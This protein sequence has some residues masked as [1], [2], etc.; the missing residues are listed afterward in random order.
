MTVRTWFGLAF[1]VMALA[2]A[3]AQAPPTN[4]VFNPSP[5]S[6]TVS[7]FSVTITFCLA[8]GYRSHKV[9]LNG[10]NITSSFSTPANAGTCTGAF[11]GDIKMTETGTV[12]PA[13]GINVLA[14]SVCESNNSR[15]G[16]P[17]CFNGGMTFTHNYVSV[18]PKNL[19]GPGPVSQTVTEQFAV[20][21][22]L[23]TA[24]TFNLAVVCSGSGVS[25]C[26]ISPASPLHIAGSTT[27]PVTVSFTSGLRNSTGL[28]KLI[29]T[30]SAQ[31]AASD[32]GSINYTAQ[33]IPSERVSTAFTS[34]AD[35]DANR[36]AEDCFAT[37]VK[38]DT[39][40]Y[41]SLD[42]ARGISLVYNS[43]EVA[44]RPVLYADVQIIPGQPYSLQGFQLSAKYYDPGSASWLTI[45]FLNGDQILHFAAVSD[46]LVHRLAGQFDA[47]AL[48]TNSGQAVVRLWMQIITSYADHSDTVSDSTHRLML[49]NGRQ[50]SVAQGWSIAG[51]SDDNWG[52]GPNPDQS[53]IMHYEGSGSTFLTG[54]VACFSW[55]CNW[56]PWDVA[57]AARL[58]YDNLPYAELDFPDSTK[59]LFQP[60]GQLWQRISRF[61]DTVTYTYDA[62]GRVTQISDPYRFQPS[63]NNTLHTYWTITYGSTWISSIIEPDSAG[64]PG[65]GRTTS[66]S[67]DAQG[68]LRSWTD[69]DHVVTKFGYDSQNR[70]DSLTD[71][72]GG[73]TTYAY[74]PNSWKLVGVTSPSVLIDNT[75]SG[76]PTPQALV[77]K[78][79]P[80]QTI[81]VP[82]TS[83]SGTPATPV[84]LSAVVAVDS[85]SSG[86][87][88]FSVNSYGQPLVVL[89]PMGDTSTF[90]YTGQGYLEG[91]IHPGGAMDAY[92]WTIPFL[93]SLTPSGAST[94]TVK[95][96]AYG[97][98]IQVSSDGLT[99]TAYIG[100]Y[101]H[102]DSVKVNGG[103]FHF[104][105]D[106]YVRDTLVVDAAHD[107]T[108]FRYDLRTGNMDSVIL[109]PSYRF[110]AKTFDGHGRDRTISSS[111]TNGVVVQT[112]AYDSVDRIVSTTDGLHTRPTTFAYDS[113]FL[114]SIT[115]PKG[116]QY[117]S[118]YNA[119]G[120]LLTET[121]SANRTASSTYSAMSAPTLE[122]NRRLQP[123]RFAY[124]PFGRLQ[125]VTRPASETNNVDVFRYSSPYG[126]VVVDSNVLVKDST[127]NSLKTGLADSSVTIFLQTGHW[128]KRK[129]TRDSLGRVTNM[130]ISTNAT[131]IDFYT[132]KSTFNPAT[133]LPQFLDLNDVSHQIAFG[134]DSILR[135]A[136]IAYP[137]GVQ[138]NDAYYSGTDAIASSSWSGLTLSRGY[139]YDSTGK[140][141][142]VDYGAGNYG[143]QSSLYTYDALGELTTNQL[144]VWKDS[145]TSCPGG[146]LQNGFGCRAG[147]T[148]KD[149][150]VQTISY[151]YDTASNLTSVLVGSTDT[152]G[153]V[154][155]ANRLSSW[156]GMTFTGD[157]DGNRLSTTTGSQTT[158]Y[159]WGAD[160][161]LLSV[162]QGS[163]T[164]TYDYDPSGQ[165]VRRSTNGTPDRYYLWDGGQILAILDGT[166][167][168][169]IEEFVYD[170]VDAP[171]ARIHG[172]AGSETIHYYAQDLAGNVIA[173]FSGTTTEQ[174]LAYDPWGAT[175]TPTDTSTTPLR[176]KG[177]LYEDGITSLY[178][179]RS[180]WYDPVT[181]RFMSPDPLGLSAGINQY[182]YAA[183]DPVNG[184]D[185]SGEDY[186]CYSVDYVVTIGGVFNDAYSRYFCN[187]TGGGAP[188]TPVD[189]PGSAHGTGG[190][191]N[192]NQNKPNC[193]KGLKP[194]KNSMAPV[195][196]TDDNGNPLLNQ[197]GQPIMRP[198]GFD[199]H[200]FTYVGAHSWFNAINKINFSQGRAWDAQRRGANY[201]SNYVDAANVF[202]GL[203]GAARGMTVEQIS[204]MANDY[205]AG[206]S[207]MKGFPDPVY[208]HLR[209]ANVW[210][211]ALGV[212]LQSSGKI[213]TAQ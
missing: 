125:T 175:T 69:P 162:T 110:K 116:Q 10:A 183:G 107:T 33:W 197:H 169:R 40:T 21:N 14:D 89:D 179:M 122:T 3:H 7:S 28:I 173:Q 156:T 187:Y 158:S 189:D 84:L 103:T 13:W 79:T 120:W 90:V 8:T 51:V 68:L 81:G 18:T 64:H 78:L 142:E 56:W 65:L 20:Q 178:Y 188:G 176:W 63:P 195:P 5:P 108:K 97:Q 27:T 115:D 137:G 194:N 192:A 164:R 200:F 12:S 146:Q 9:T 157:S 26:S 191:V 37:H 70:L 57:V 170:G 48:A 151:A 96:G 100:K 39:P 159:S 11:N 22:L 186:F 50:S 212:D 138:R 147:S 129:Y 47:H 155:P 55:G 144:L 204:E 182:S 114:R 199:P 82:L 62:Q 15:T 88:S 166:A 153:T 213:C 165:L 134:Y 109:W 77:R 198:V 71:R 207:V 106:A 177:L 136:A 211:Y 180:R 75:G 87:T 45:Q 58:H 66:I 149:S 102:T 154:L 124:D 38:M 209:S 29:A 17:V 210:D 119:L 60:N 86:K 74:D 72:E 23:T 196:F 101:G 163:T 201:Y 49:V 181:R 25:G 46:T 80:W 167:N 143:T 123:T 172:P 67:V 152:V 95:Y 112:T 193:P 41:T 2:P 148:R 132:R 171:L 135:P 141:S 6:A 203:W 19:N 92:T 1:T 43:D 94:T 104:Y 133:G 53:Y 121:D 126:Q 184:E 4:F 93:T 131:G 113:L 117:R 139:G 52:T 127:Y 150:V 185:P 34:P 160:G 208:T 16:P 128:F 205:A 190:G 91:V 73:L 54:P 32:T 130:A 44:V 36:C 30:D 61:N 76:S 206:H 174:S 83:T 31:T 98:V 105:A 85:V 161:R 99:D 59:E 145:L 202:I 118:T 140:I 35:Q 168:T 111:T 24:A 42:V